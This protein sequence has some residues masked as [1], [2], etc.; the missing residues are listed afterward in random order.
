MRRL[1]VKIVEEVKATKTDLAELILHMHDSNRAPVTCVLKH[2]FLVYFR[3]LDLRF[4]DAYA[5]RRPWRHK[6]CPSRKFKG[7]KCQFHILCPHYNWVSHLSLTICNMS[8]RTG[9][10]LPV[11]PPNFSFINFIRNFCHNNCDSHSD[12]EKTPISCHTQTK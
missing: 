5:C 7:S 11:G 3:D 6:L 2:N 1:E 10:F 12:N 4:E 9:A 8:Q